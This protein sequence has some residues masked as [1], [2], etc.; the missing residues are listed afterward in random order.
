MLILDRYIVAGVVKRLVVV[1]LVLSGV[2]ATYAAAVFLSK[3]ASGLLAPEAIVKL[4]FLKVV[5]AAEVVVP[6]SLYVAVILTFERL[7][8]TRETTA[9]AAGGFSP[10]QTAMG[11]L[12]AFVVVA[13]VVGGLT[14]IGR[15]RAYTA[16]YDLRREAEA[17]FDLSSIDAG[18]FYPDA[19]GERV[20]FVE[21][22]RARGDVMQGVFVWVDQEGDSI[23]MLSAREAERVADAPDG[24]GRVELRNLSVYEMDENGL[25]LR[26]EAGTVAA[27]VGLGKIAPVGY[28]RKAAT[29]AYLACS[30]DEEDR[31]EF[32]WRVS[33]PFS[34]LILGFLALR[35]S[36]RPLRSG[37]SFWRVVLTIGACVGYFMLSI[38]A[39][40]Q[41]KDGVVGAFPGMWWVDVA[42]ALLLLSGFPWDRVRPMRRRSKAVA[43]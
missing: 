13:L 26:G 24:G 18:R 28:K 4:V 40:N 38:T 1:M 43:A 8:R 20:V 33:R 22:V 39:R 31:A 14:M 32:Q 5:I 3:A 25:R 6:I 12:T 30:D 29:T 21:A 9:M 34:V 41:V 7:H 19:D 37:R 36:R 2:F 15:P 10:R 35:M 16:M 27:E 23:L 17:A 11:L 42:F